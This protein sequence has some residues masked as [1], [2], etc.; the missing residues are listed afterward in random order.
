MWR[1][2][3]TVWRG[4]TTVWRGRTTV[5]RGR[6]TVWRGRTTVWRGR[7]TVWRGRTTV[8]RGRTTVWRGRTSKSHKKEIMSLLSFHSYG[9][10]LSAMGQYYLHGTISKA[11]PTR[12]G[13]LFLYSFVRRRRRSAW[14]HMAAASHTLSP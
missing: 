5:W 3:T 13:F 12:G 7:T 2:R 11:P 8:W 1:G 6:T 10:L 9:T 14:P 4:R